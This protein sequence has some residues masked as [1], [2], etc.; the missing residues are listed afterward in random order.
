MQITE[1]QH[2]AAG[3]I[4]E[5][6]ATKLG[7]NRAVHSGTAISVCARLSGSF[8]FRSFNFPMK[9]GTPGNSVL[10]EE[11]NEKGPV[12]INIL[13]GMLEHLG[14]HIDAKK[15]DEISMAESDLNFLDS[16]I[17]LQDKAALIMNQYKLNYEQMAYSCAMATAFIIKECQQDLQAASGF[18]T[19]V[20][21]FIEGTKTYPPELSDPGSGKKSFFS[22]WK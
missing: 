9:N 10:S 22:F 8:M 12:L 20:Y 5:L 4:V 19:A 6:I 13:G 14:I 11:A 17:L 1:Q 18:N 15:L 21:S 16:M 7:K 3:E 2:K